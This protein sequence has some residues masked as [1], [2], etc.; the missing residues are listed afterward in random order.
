MPEIVNND[1][2]RKLIKSIS[3]NLIRAQKEESNRT[4]RTIRNNYLDKASADSVYLAKILLE[5]GEL[6]ECSKYFLSAAYSYEKV[7]ACNQSMACYDKLLELGVDEFIDKAKDGLNRLASFKR[8]EIDITSKE[9]KINALDFLIW[10][11][12]GATTTKAK[13]YFSE[14]F[15]LEISTASIRSYAHE[16]NERKRVIIW[17][18]PQG[19]E[20]HIYPNMADLATRTR[21]YGKSSLFEGS[22]ESRITEEF[23]INFN[24]LSYNKELFI[25]NEFIKPKMIMAVDVEGF[26]RNLNKFTENGFLIKAKGVLRRFTDLQSSGYELSSDVQAND[27]K[28]HTNDKLDV[29]DSKI[30]L[31]GLTGEVIY[32]SATA[33]DN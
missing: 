27:Y 22:I 8:D 20:Y 9:G 17:G 25:I 16:L 6:E 4:D 15:D 33:G 10:K 24:R 11:Y 19:R 7:G 2:I 32:E 21:H 5:M 30:L 13:V 3:S 18:G 14:E 29:I 31:D 23:N 26:V 28:I 1:Q 12:Y